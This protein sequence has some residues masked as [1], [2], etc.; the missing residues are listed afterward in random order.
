[1]PFWRT[2]SGSIGVMMM[3]M[4]TSFIWPAAS[5]AALMAIAGSDG[6]GGGG[7][8]DDAKVA[9]NLSPFFGNW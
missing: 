9:E 8:S 5:A 6:G 1:M 3:G 4:E 7:G 2:V